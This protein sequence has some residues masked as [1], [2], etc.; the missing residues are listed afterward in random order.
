MLLR[1]PPH[2]YVPV[3]M[4]THTSHGGGADAPWWVVAGIVVSIIVA[5]VSLG[6]LATYLAERH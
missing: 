3:F 2:V 1:I 5:G 6:V 4:G